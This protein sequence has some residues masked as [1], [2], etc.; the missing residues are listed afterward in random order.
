MKRVENVF[1][2]PGFSVKDDLRDRNCDSRLRLS[3]LRIRLSSAMG[4]DGWTNQTPVTTLT[5][6]V[7]TNCCRANG[8]DLKQ[9][10]WWSALWMPDGSTPGEWSTDLAQTID[11][12]SRVLSCSTIVCCSVSLPSNCPVRARWWRAVVRP[13]PLRRCFPPSQFCWSTIGLLPHCC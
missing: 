1:M 6:K 4:W 12:M 3:A 2:A 11:P 5:R 8:S 13:F 7:A 9:V 10:A